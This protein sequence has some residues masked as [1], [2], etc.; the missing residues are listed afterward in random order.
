VRKGKR[1]RALKRV[2]RREKEGMERGTEKK[3][4]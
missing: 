2:W 1:K 4:R 3:E